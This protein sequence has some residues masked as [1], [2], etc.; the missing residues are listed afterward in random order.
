MNKGELS[1]FVLIPRTKIDFPAPGWPL[2]SLTIKPAV[3]PSR[4]EMAS[5]TGMP[6][7]SLAVTLAMEPVETR[8]FCRP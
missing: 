7:M 2:D 4:V 8:F 3:C 1:P 5:G 6:S